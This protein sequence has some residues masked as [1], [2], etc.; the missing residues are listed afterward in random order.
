MW[1][2]IILCNVRI[3]VIYVNIW[4]CFCICI[5]I[6]IV[7]TV[8]VGRSCISVWRINYVWIITNVSCSR[9]RS[10]RFPCSPPATPR[11]SSSD[12][13]WR[14]TIYSCEFI[15]PYVVGFIDINRFQKSNFLCFAFRCATLIFGI[16]CT[17][18]F[19][20]NNWSNVSPMHVF[21]CGV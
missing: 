15:T 5:T 18:E 11:T 9:R 10:F 7:I 12:S 3:C 2:L 21:P 13:N 19:P 20:F 1:L 4:I 16:L 8:L 14:S 6:R 17:L